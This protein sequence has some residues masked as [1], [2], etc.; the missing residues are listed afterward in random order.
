MAESALAEP[1]R[2]VGALGW[3]RHDNEGDNRMLR[4][5]TETLAPLD[6]VP[7]E[8]HFEPNAD[9]IRRLNLLDFVL[10]G[11][12]TLISGTPTK[13][14]ERFHQWEQN[15][16]TP[17]GVLGLGIDHIAPDARV[18]TEALVSRSEFFYVRDRA[19]GEQ[20]DH[21]KVRVSADLTFASPLAAEPPL[22]LLGRSAVCGV[23][24]RSSAG[25]DVQHWLRA[26]KKLPFALRGVPLSTYRP[27]QEAA[28]L[29]EVDPGCAPCFSP[30]LYDGLDVFVG[31]AYH[32]VVFAAQCAVPVVAICYS[33]KV[34]RLMVELG[35]EDFA[36]LPDDWHGLANAVN[37]AM[38]D[39]HS[40]SERLTN[41]SARMTIEAQAML[42]HIRQCVQQPRLPK[43]RSPSSISVIVMASVSSEATERTAR[44]CRS[45]T[46]RHVKTVL[47]PTDNT[48][49]SRH[50]SMARVVSTR[51][52]IGEGDRD[53]AENLNHALQ[54]V[55][56]EY[57]TWVTAGSE[58]APDAL[59]NMAA[60]LDAHP[61]ASVAYSDWF[62]VDDRGLL[63]EPLPA[64]P[65]EKLW[66]RNVIGPSFMLRKCIIDE[67]DG[68]SQD[69]SLPDYGLWLW[70]FPT[71][72]FRPIRARLFYSY[73]TRSVERQSALERE[74][75]QRM[76]R[77][78]RWPRRAAQAILDEER[79]GRLVVE[80]ILGIRRS[81]LSLLRRH[82]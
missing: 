22:S 6:V 2:A 34:R 17:I 50:A 32:S 75:R 10:L 29:E 64:G 28:I 56:G 16:E 66:R 82:G 59:A 77:M 14:F 11:G 18:A 71:H 78:L 73:P 26:I 7:I 3:W 62:A 76:R 46:L 36:L 69:I 9:G 38:T 40:I 45:Q 47:V 41:A 54:D 37:R 61:E 52:P 42:T 24:L 68:F 60:V 35:L 44:S 74:V 13:P 27:F 33:P 65:P 67:Y 58:Y 25:L 5:V 15:L 55:S 79:V 23:N 43:L 49:A 20:I 30:R 48:V 8:T 1:V 72:K 53:H 12:G 51:C 57:V 63:L 31:T 19:S 39:R 70:A 21:P 81:L 4:T 80:P